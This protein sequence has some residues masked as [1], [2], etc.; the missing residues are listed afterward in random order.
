MI[1]VCMEMFQ[2]SDNC[3]DECMNINLTIY[4]GGHVGLEIII[5]SNREKWRIKMSSSI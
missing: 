4:T 5:F 1:A 2:S 3:P